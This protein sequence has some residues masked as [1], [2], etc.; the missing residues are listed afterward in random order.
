M[1]NN[2]MKFVLFILGIS[3]LISCNQG[4]LKKINEENTALKTELD[5]LK[6][7]IK[8]EAEKKKFLGLYVNTKGG[9]YNKIEFKGETS[10]VVTDGIF[11]MPFATSYERDGSIIRIRTDKS[12][13]MLTIKDSETLIGE[14]FAEGTYK[15]KE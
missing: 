6:N 5:S 11:G 1:I 9:L 4:E 2:P 8:Q 13:L 7:Y 10:C 3:L 14:G 12:D 15:K